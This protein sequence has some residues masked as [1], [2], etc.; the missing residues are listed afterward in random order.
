MRPLQW[1]V[2]FG[3]SSFL[4]HVL[5]KILPLSTTGKYPCSLEVNRRGASMRL[6]RDA[7]GDTTGGELPTDADPSPTEVDVSAQEL[8]LQS[9]AERRPLLAERRDDTQQQRHHYCWV[10]LDD[11]IST[12]FTTK[13]KVL[14]VQQNVPCQ[15]LTI[16]YD[17]CGLILL[18]YSFARCILLL[19]MFKVQL[20]FFLLGLWII[21]TFFF[22]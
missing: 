21:Q 2:L 16:I 14:I 20:F 10:L 22:K 6:W 15:C 5:Q 3:G 13:V 18:L 12:S 1:A 9:A 4:F 7:W 19:K 11:L 8:R 17:V